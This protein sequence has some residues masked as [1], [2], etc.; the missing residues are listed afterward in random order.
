MLHELKTHRMMRVGFQLA[1]VTKSCTFGPLDP[2]VGA[3]YPIQQ[4]P[5]TWDRVNVEL[6]L[7]LVEGECGI[8]G[9]KKKTK[10]SWMFSSFCRGSLHGASLEIHIMDH[11]YS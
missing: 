10:V 4:K 2:C 9:I 1:L 7:L 3:L 5:G 8:C 6:V 11:E